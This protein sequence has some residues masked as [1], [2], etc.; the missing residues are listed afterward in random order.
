MGARWSPAA[1]QNEQD[2]MEDNR[3]YIKSRVK[4]TAYEWHLN[5]LD[6][7][8]LKKAKKIHSYYKNLHKS[9]HWLV[10]QV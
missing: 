8:A 5:D 6:N 3:C 2:S 4:S 9:R 7:T 1:A 10:S